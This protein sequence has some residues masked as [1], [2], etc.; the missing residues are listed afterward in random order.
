MSRSFFNLLVLLGITTTAY[1]EEQLPL[2]VPVTPRWALECWLW[3]DDHSTAAAITELLDGFA[4][5]DIPAR[6]IILDAPWSMR[7]NDFQFDPKRYPNVEEFFKELKR[8]DIR[9]IMW[10]TCMVN[11]ENASTAIKNSKD[12]YEEAKAKGYLA[13]GGYEQ[14]WW[15][16]WGGFVDYENPEAM[17]WWHG[18]QQK[19]YDMGIDGWKLDDAAFYFN[20]IIGNV[21]GIRNM[22]TNANRGS[23]ISNRK[24]VDHFYRDEYHWGQKQ[25]GKDFITLARSIDTKVYPKGF[26]PLDVA[27]V[28]WVGDQRHTWKASEEGIEE[29]LNYILEAARQGYCVIGSDVGGYHGGMPIPKNLYIR[30]AQF[31]CFCGLFLNGGHEERRLWLRSKEELEIIR[32]YAWLHNELI[33]YMYSHVV[34]CHRGGKTLMRPIGSSDFAG[35]D[36]GSYHY[37]F[38]DDFL[39]VP[40]HEDKLGRTVNLP[41]GKWRYF[42]DDSKVIEGP[43]TITRDFALHEFPIYIREGAIIPLD[44]S[45]PY[46]GLG[47]RDSAN[48]ITWNI[49]PADGNQ[50]TLHHSEAS[51]TTARVNLKEVLEVSLEGEPKPHLLRVYREKE[52]KSVARD[53]N[54]LRKGIDWRFDAASHRLWVRQERPANGNYVIR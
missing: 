1:G 31:S 29:A 24:Y 10:M 26:C 25:R 42:F 35:R 36:L 9:I 43:A 18:M 53:G 11:S 54:E 44:V 16:G 45:R 22:P 21:T 49:Y 37:L 46:T 5:H 23:W 50:F 30:W 3:E 20:S 28:T 39:I 14:H 32:V 51:S 17:K 4:K 7:Y 8:R 40:I 52:P 34:E 38:G 19:V 41:A 33:P 48:L 47:D 27:P 13:G 2:R 12:W 15:Q 6:T